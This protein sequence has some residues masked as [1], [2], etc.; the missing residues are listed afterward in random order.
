MMGATADHIVETTTSPG[1]CPGLPP[2]VQAR[3]RRSLGDGHGGTAR[4]RPP[5]GG[6]RQPLPGEEPTT[7][8]TLPD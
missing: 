2:A 5:P 8:P 3:Y 7:S 4:S 6:R 1:L